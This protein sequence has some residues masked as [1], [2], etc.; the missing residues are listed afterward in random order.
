MAVSVD[1]W[2][3]EILARAHK[4][5]LGMVLVHRGVVRATS[6]EGRPVRGMHLHYDPQ[7]LEEVVEDLKSREGIE[8]I[9]VWIN[10]GPL[11]V[12]DDI[13]VVLVAG[14]FRRDVLPVMEELL[15]RI[16][17]EVVKEEEF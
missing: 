5:N 17:R 3:E 16:K 4:G 9:R 1:K 11:K 2:M 7:K 8:A 12:G 13:M 15:S 6:R 10:Q 14:R